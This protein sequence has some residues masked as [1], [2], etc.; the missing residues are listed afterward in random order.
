MKEIIFCDTLHN[1]Q[2]RDKM[3]SSSIPTIFLS[4]INNITTHFIDV[5]RSEYLKDVW[6]S[7]SELA[8]P[9]LSTPLHLCAYLMITPEARKQFLNI[10]IK[11][12]NL[13]PPDISI[14]VV[15]QMLAE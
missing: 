6:F 2:I 1:L 7:S 8:F 12:P 5:G 11:N 4:N 3:T 14:D 9:V 15:L 10:L 13:R